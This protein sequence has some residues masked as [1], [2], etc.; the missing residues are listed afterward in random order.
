MRVTGNEPSR[1]CPWLKLDSQ[2]PPEERIQYRVSDAVI[3]QF[4]IAAQI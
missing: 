4:P 1:F 2:Q 3:G